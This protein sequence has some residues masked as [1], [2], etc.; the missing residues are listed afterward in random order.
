[1]FIIKDSFGFLGNTKPNIIELPPVSNQIRKD[2]SS[3]AFITSLF[4]LVRGIKDYLVAMDINISNCHRSERSERKVAYHCIIVKMYG[5]KSISLFLFLFIL[6]V[7]CNFESKL[8]GS[9]K[10]SKIAPHPIP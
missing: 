6:F 1:M 8:P 9:L 4:V 3:L 7:C 10:K 5:G 2:S